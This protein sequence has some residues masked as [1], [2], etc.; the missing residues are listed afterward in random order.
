M[1]SCNTETQNA[2]DLVLDFG[3]NY[4]EPL[5][6]K[7]IKKTLIVVLNP[8]EC[9]SCEEEVIHFVN[10]AYLNFNSIT[11]IPQ[12]VQISPRIH[13]SKTIAVNR[14][15]LAQH[16][17]LNANGSVLVYEGKNCIYFSPIDLLNIDQLKKDLD[18]FKN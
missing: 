10:S 4:L 9:G 14:K 3:K 2:P 17:L 18:S 6:D 8:S 7:G 13:K 1:V 15:K 16:S 5:L 11:I 12:N